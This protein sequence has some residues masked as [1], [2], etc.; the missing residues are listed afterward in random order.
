M[1]RPSGLQDGWP[2]FANCVLVRRVQVP[3]AG[4]MRQ[5]SGLPKGF[6]RMIATCVPSGE[7]VA[8]VVRPPKPYASR[9]FPVFTSSSKICGALFR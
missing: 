2:S 5:S 7:T 4:V 6:D 9:R 8:P 3:D 1:L